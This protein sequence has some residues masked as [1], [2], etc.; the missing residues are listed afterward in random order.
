MTA[1]ADR[2]TGALNKQRWIA[3]VD[4]PFLPAHGGGEQEHFGLLRAASRAG[5]L[6]LVV[7]P[8]PVDVDL[9]PYRQVLGGV[10]LLA[11]PRRGSPL[12]LLHPR[13]PFVVASRPAPRWITRRAREL[14]PGAT[15]V[16]TTSYKSWRVGERL[17]RELEL[18]VVLRHQNREG[19]YHRSLAAGLTGPRRWVMRWEAAR[20]SRDENRLGRAGWLQGTAD[21]SAADA[22]ARRSA[23]GRNVVH[24]PPFAFDPRAAGTVER[25]PD[26]EPRV[27]FLGALDVPTNITALDWLLTQVWPLVRVGA[28]S[29]VLDVV[30][31][32][33]SPGLRQR[34]E[35][36]SGVQLHADVPDIAPF[37]AR[38]AVAV[39]PAVSGSG[40]NV[41]VIDYL[42]AG[43]PLVSTSLATRGL[44][45]VAGIDLEVSDEPAGFAAAVLRLLEDR[46]AAQTL[47]AHGQAHMA[48]LLD[49]ET[50]LLRIARLLGVV[51]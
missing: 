7:M 42:Q 6:S 31:R 29:A 25:C 39:N 28:P 2:T 21:I 36:S 38:S 51:D 33:P 48:G 8:A 23:G 35:S 49:P 32:R 14:A 4:S 40:V 9:E 26:A 27:V 16:V 12:L 22:E 46:A 11:T 43:V 37:L 24:V 44:P 3:V 34:L 50:N 15:A 20:I 5:I 18:P 30:G 1:S 45:L 10:A 17:A 19:D 47:A 13:D 41:K